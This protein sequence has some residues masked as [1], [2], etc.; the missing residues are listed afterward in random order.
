MD[1]PN[2]T[3]EEYIRLEEEK[4][5]RRGKVYNWETAT[6]AIVYNDTFTSEVT[7]SCE[8]AVSPLN[9]N[10]IDFRISFEEFDGEDYTVI[11][12]KKSFSYKIIFVNYLKM[13]L[14]NDNEKAN[15]PSFLSPEPTVSYFD[16]LDFL[17]DFENEFP[18]I[19][20]NDALTSKSDSSTGPVKIPH[21]IDEFDLKDET[22]LSECDEEEQN[23]L[24]FNDLFPFNIY[25]PDDSKSNKDNDDHEID[26]KHS[27]G[28][29]GPCCKEIDDMVDHSLF[30]LRID[31]FNKEI[32]SGVGEDIIVFDMNGI[33][34]HSVSLVEKVCMINEPTCDSSLKECNGGD[35]IH[36]LDEHGNIKKWECNNDNE[37]RNEK[38]KEMSFSNLLLIKYGNSIIDDAARARIYIEWYKSEIVK[39][40]YFK[41]FRRV[42]VGI[43]MRIEQLA[44][45]YEL[46]IGKKG[47]VLY[48]IWEKCELV[49]RGTMYSW[50][51]KRFKKEERWESDLD[52]KYYDPSV[53]LI[54]FILT[55]FLS[56]IE[57]F[58]VKRIRICERKKIVCVTI[59]LD[60]F[61]IRD[62]V[63]RGK[64]N[65]NDSERIMD[66]GGS[67]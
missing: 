59:M 21:R 48:D 8:P 56:C 41:K 4:A 34:H 25:H 20:Y 33:V 7:L 45:E 58:K 46:G 64:V 51:D 65:G 2:L 9:D 18:A 37:R 26:I 30:M 16:D 50:H 6:Y 52:E 44:D 1:D 3:M 35:R 17:K 62:E 42:H 39:D 15:M 61:A 53:I 12:E 36:R 11:Y 57:S 38:G 63:E 19:V 27:L 5:R 55:L 49:H 29:G 28:G 24:Y 13:D 54:L 47:Y 14:E 22:T 67:V 32:L 43:E 31:V 10:K 66:T 23:V 40:P 60:V